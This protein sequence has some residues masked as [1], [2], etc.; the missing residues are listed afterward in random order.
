LGISLNTEGNWV[1][2]P[3]LPKTFV[4]NVGDQLS[5]WS[6]DLFLS[7]VH[8]AINRDSVR[9]FS[10]P[11][12]FGVDY[13]VPLETIESCVSEGNPKKYETVLAGDVSPP[14]PILPEVQIH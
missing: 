3:P 12:F 5:R 11:F 9:R 6:N 14:V 2:A 10:I 8:R 7:T 1:P 13:D 4:I